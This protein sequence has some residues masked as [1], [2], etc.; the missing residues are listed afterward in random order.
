MAVIAFLLW[1]TWMAPDV[2]VIAGAG[3]A[4]DGRTLSSDDA[5]RAGDVIRAGE[6]GLV[7]R[8]WDGTRIELTAGS[9]LTIALAKSLRLES[10][11]LHAE[12]AKQHGGETV[13]IE[14]S[15]ARSTI[16][17]TRFT[18]EA[19]P[20]RTRLVVEEGAVRFADLALGVE[21]LVR[22]GETAEVQA[23]RA[24]P[25]ASPIEIPQLGLALWLRAD[26]AVAAGA[27]PL[28]RWRDRSGHGR[29]A[30]QGEAA[31]R[32]TAMHGALGDV[33]SFDATARDELDFPLAVNGWRGM[34]IALVAAC[35]VDSS[36]S[37]SKN[38]AVFWDETAIWGNVYVSPFRST[39][40]W[41]FGTTQVGNLPTWTR[42][43]P[44]SG[45][46]LIVTRKAETQD[47]LF[48]DG[49]LVLRESARLPA[50]AACTDTGM[51]GRGIQSTFWS[52]AI[53]ELVVYDRALDDGERMTLE[54]WLGEHR[55]LDR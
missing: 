3:V 33:V 10:G 20:G 19:D 51:L 1:T 49:H 40:N 44:D 47:E 14:T 21:R 7:L 50:I 55:R 2:R 11:S 24:S 28:A 30:V 39:I 25:P 35:A 17:G 5:V 18:L 13:S 48:V 16:V 15:L 43:V 26:D 41:R 45:F 8:W 22:S 27:G 36:D 31:R 23:A 9:G 46:T 32:P 37:S 12:V 54:R 42:P 52:G 34:T 29:D 4:A 53:A 6:H 38:A